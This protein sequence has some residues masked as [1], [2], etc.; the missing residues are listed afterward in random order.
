MTGQILLAEVIDGGRLRMLLALSGGITPK[1]N[2]GLPVLG[3]AA[4]L[5]GRE[6]AVPA[7]RGLSDRSS[8]AVS[9]AVFQD[10]GFDALGRD[11]D[12]EAWDF[13]IPGDD[14]L[15]G[16][17][18]AVDQALGDPGHGVVLCRTT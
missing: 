1:C 16:G 6:R 5:V 14:L 12:A 3:D 2:A 18:E 13:V 4:G 15:L 17:L 9:G 8:A 10:V 11:A 7:D